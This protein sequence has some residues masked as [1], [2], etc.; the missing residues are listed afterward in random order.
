MLVA[1]R[2]FFVAGRAKR[3][4]NPY[5]TDGLVAMWDA[6]WN[7]GPGVH[8]T[9]VRKL[10][11]LSGNGRDATLL[12]S[13]VFGSNFVRGNGSTYVAT[14]GFDSVLPASVR[15]ISV[16]CDVATPTGT[17]GR[18]SQCLID[19]GNN[20]NFFSFG[21]D[22]GGY[23]FLMRTTTKRRAA[24]A[25]GA[26]SCYAENPSGSTYNYRINGSSVSAVGGTLF[27]HTGAR[28][29]GRIGGAWGITTNDSYPAAYFRA[30]SKIHSIR[31]YSRVLAATEVA[32]IYAIDKERFHLS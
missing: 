23:L 14:F 21:Y 29:S 6:E 16:C 25:L 8:D 1:A 3:W 19:S 22:A 15:S 28:T 17:T 7:A 9:T 11:D 24:G 13:A 31:L 30:D 10:V 27:D 4:T 5:D 2:S 18:Y 12:S 32:G 26:K 20:T